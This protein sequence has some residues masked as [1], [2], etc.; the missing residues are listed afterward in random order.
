MQ[1]EH[2]ALQNSISQVWHLVLE[3]PSEAP[4]LVVMLSSIVDLIKG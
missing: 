1:D 2:Q 3:R 4:S